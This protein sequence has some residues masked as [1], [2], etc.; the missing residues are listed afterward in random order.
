M[1]EQAGVL[2]VDKPEGPTS[3]DVVA[4]ARRALGTRRIGHT[5]TLD[6]F[7]SGLLILCIGPATRLAEYLTAQP[8]TYRAVM[9]LGETTDT[10]DFTGDVI[11]HSDGWD[12]VDEAQVLAALRTQTGVLQQLPPL[13]S[14]KKVGGVRAYAAARRGEAVERKPSTVTVYRIELLR[15]DLPEL[16][17]EVECSS[18]TYIR[19]IARDVGEAL[20]VGAHLRALRRTAIGSVRVEDAV[21]LDRLADVERVRAALLSPADAVRHLA[22]L[23]LPEDQVAAVGQGRSVP[24]PAGRAEGEPVAMLDAS[25]TLVAIGEVRGAVIQ[26]RKVFV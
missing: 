1:A 8:K 19:A 14:A 16:E 11:R 21:P 23:R 13:F 22:S 12:A 4:A 26:P 6:P 18:G 24:A 10:D 2:P 25:G 7:A 5:G 15:I 17:F 3:H 20:A 9:R